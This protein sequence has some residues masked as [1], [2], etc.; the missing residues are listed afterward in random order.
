MPRRAEFTETAPG[1]SVARRGLPARS[2]SVRSGQWDCS[3]GAGQQCAPALGN[4]A[5]EAGRQEAS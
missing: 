2:G 5:L 4:S 3:V 1:V